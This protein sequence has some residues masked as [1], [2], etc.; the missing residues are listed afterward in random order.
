[1]KG[2]LKPRGWA[3]TTRPN[4]GEA[5]GTLAAL[6]QLLNPECAEFPVLQSHKVRHQAAT[7]HEVHG[8]EANPHTTQ[9]NA[10]QR[11][12]MQYDSQLITSVT[13]QAVERSP[14]TC[15]V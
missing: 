11:N 2:I 9:H 14:V 12:S 8:G 1:M 7:P 5:R 10:V 4:D 13:S 6:L 15:D 3:L